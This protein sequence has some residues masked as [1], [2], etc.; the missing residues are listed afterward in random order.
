M[1]TELDGASIRNLAVL[2]GGWTLIAAGLLSLPLPAPCSAP[3]LALGGVVLSQRSMTFR[4]G[5]ARVRSR[6]PRL[7]ASLTRRCRKWPRPM[8]YVVLRTDPRRISA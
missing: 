6:A 4:R 7:S 5:V 2:A 1:W 8:R 3:V